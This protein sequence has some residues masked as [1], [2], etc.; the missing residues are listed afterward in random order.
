MIS[1][2]F[3]A[4]LWLALALLAGQQAAALHNL[5]HATERLGGKTDGTTAQHT[6]AQCFF[7]AQLAGA[8]V[9]TIPAVAMVALGAPL[10]LHVLTLEAPAATRFAFLSRAPPLFL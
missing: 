10:L 9:A 5:G 7:S 6:C 2:R 1:R 3:F 4:A 8:V